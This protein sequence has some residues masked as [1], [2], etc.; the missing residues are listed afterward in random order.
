[1]RNPHWGCTV[2]AVLEPSALVQHSKSTH[3]TKEADRSR[4]YSM[5]FSKVRTSKT[6]FF[7]WIILKCILTSFLKQPKGKSLT[8]L[9]SASFTCSCANCVSVIFCSKKILP[10]NDSKM[11]SIGGAKFYE[12]V[13]SLRKMRLALSKL[14]TSILQRVQSGCPNNSIRTKELWEESKKA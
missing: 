14:V 9:L 6:P 13:L 1:M 12:I 7:P 10:K 5:G 4:C 2:E 8:S 11:Q 3:A